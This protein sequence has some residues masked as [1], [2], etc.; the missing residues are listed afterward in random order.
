MSFGMSAGGGDR[1]EDLI[2]SPPHIDLVLFTLTLRRVVEG[3]ME[4]LI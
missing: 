1:Y 2:L 3:L 4:T